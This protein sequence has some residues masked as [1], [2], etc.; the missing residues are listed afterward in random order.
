MGSTNGLKVREGNRRRT[1]GLPP[2][3][4]L[5]VFFRAV[6][7]LAVFFAMSHPLDG[8]YATSSVLA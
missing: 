8:I 7:F 5:A 3:R 1:A 6:V 4:F 2:A